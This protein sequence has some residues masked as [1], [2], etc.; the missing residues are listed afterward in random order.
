MKNDME[1]ET[2][3]EPEQEQ[4]AP[5]SI[6]TL[7][8]KAMELITITNNP[9]HLVKY[10]HIVDEVMDKYGDFLLDTKEEMGDEAIAPAKIALLEQQ[11]DRLLRELDAE[12][13]AYL[14]E[15]KAFNAKYF[16]DM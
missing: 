4:I 11:E 7:M 9:S 15:E 5:V 6:E 16:P 10:Q 2:V 13:T 3:R 8:D 1:N 14:K 12:I